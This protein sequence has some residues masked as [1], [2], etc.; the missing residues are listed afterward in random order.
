M[1]VVAGLGRGRSVAVVAGLL[2]ALVVAGCGSSGRADPTRSAAAGPPSGGSGLS[3]SSTTTT[4]SSSTHTSSTRRVAAVPHA[5]FAVGERIVTI[6]DY[7]RH[8]RY[9]GGS[10]QPRR[11][12]TIIRYPALG[13]ASRVDVPN[14][15]PARAAGPFPLLVFGHGYAVTPD[16]YAPLLQ[17]WAREGYVVAAPIFPLENAN[18]PGGP[19][20]NDL[21]NQPADMSY[22]ITKVL[23]ADG[24]RSSLFYG[25]VN[26]REVAV[27]GQSDGGETALAVAYDRYFLD[28]RVRA[29]AILSGAVI[30]G[31]GGFSF[32]AP[33]P[34][35]L[36]TQGTADVVN[37][38]S[39]TFGFYNIAPRP[40]YLLTLYGA[41][42]LAP[43]TGIEP[44]TAVTERVTTDFFDH[45]LKG[46]PRAPARMRRDGDVGGVSSLRS[47]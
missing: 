34:P 33:S 29:A 47:G 37:P 8:V 3:S 17:H 35:L 1:A 11:L 44:Y 24:N 14:A 21:V 28:R 19:N 16:I 42:H 32:P 40:K 10:P 12:V 46:W 15:R 23:K 13:P 31:V 2:A 18:A 43:Y 4:S 5:P 26:R 41:S 30:P 6:V 9:P 38:P 36:A 45:Y 39:F 20:E 25:L 27:T 7:S 22:I